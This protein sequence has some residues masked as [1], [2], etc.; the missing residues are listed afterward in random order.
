[1]GGVARRVDAGGLGSRIEHPA[2]RFYNRNVTDGEAALFDEVTDA[3]I[4][5]IHFD[6][7]DDNKAAVIFRNNTV[8]TQGA[9]LKLVGCS[10]TTDNAGTPNAIA[11]EIEGTT[12]GI[13]FSAYFEE[14]HA[15]N[16]FLCVTD[17]NTILK[18]MEESGD[19]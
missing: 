2:V 10:F 17:T 9:N 8:G 12:A 6:S 19:S 15:D 3:Y 7:V 13:Q 18:E 5:G 14:C 4:Q 16:G 11:A 1:M